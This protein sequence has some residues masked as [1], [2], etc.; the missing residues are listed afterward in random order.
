MALVAFDSSISPNTP[1]SPK[2]AA[3]VTTL[4]AVNATQ[5]SCDK[6]DFRGFK[7]LSVKPP[8]GV[9][10]LTF[11]G[12][13]ASGDTFVLINDLGTNGVVSVTASVWNVIDYT[14]LA[15]HHFI[16]MQSTGGNGNASCLA[17]T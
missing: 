10:A 14:K 7:F 5:G 13:A 2:K 4:V 1:S 9:T 17:S 15:P 8:A 6:L 3:T 16:Q 12:A 11:Y